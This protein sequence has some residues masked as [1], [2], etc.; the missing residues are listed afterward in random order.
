MTA[1]LGHKVLDRLRSRS[2]WRLPGF[3]AQSYAAWPYTAASRV[4][5][6]R[7]LLRRSP[8]GRRSYPAGVGTLAT[9]G[10]AQLE[11]DV[12]GRWEVVALMFVHLVD[13]PPGQPVSA[14]RC[15]HCEGWLPN[16]CGS[17]RRVWHRRGGHVVWKPLI[18]HRQGREPTL[19]PPTADR[20]RQEAAT[21]L[22]SVPVGRSMM[23][24]ATS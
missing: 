13:P 1:K 17:I 21:S 9:A 23:S 12:D 22:P 24:C 5:S 7:N 20:N 19:T 15:S 10:K 14:L 3:C 16:S 4:M 18:R 6:C 8:S 2:A 11:L